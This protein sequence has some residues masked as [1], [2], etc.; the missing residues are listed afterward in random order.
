MEESVVFSARSGGN[1]AAYGRRATLDGMLESAWPL[2]CPDVALT[3]GRAEVGFDR[4]EYAADVTGLRAVCLR[5]YGLVAC[6]GRIAAE[7][8]PAGAGDR[9]LAALADRAFAPAADTPLPCGPAGGG[10]RPVVT[11][12][13]RIVLRGE[14]VEA[15]P[16][17]TLEVCGVWICGA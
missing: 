1:G 9:E 6:T 13:G 7:A 16:A 10:R 3:Q 17:Q 12:E 15:V 5:A 14:A 8:L 2:V 11:K 4:G